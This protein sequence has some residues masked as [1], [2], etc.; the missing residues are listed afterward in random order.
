[1]GEL[2]C[3]FG[4]TRGDT[5]R[6]IAM[7]DG[8]S[9]VAM[10]LTSLLDSQTSPLHDEK[11][12]LKR[13][14]TVPALSNPTRR[15]LT[16]R[17]DWR[18]VAKKNDS[19]RLAEINGVNMFSMKYDVS[20]NQDTLYGRND[21]PLL[22]FDYSETGELRRVLDGT[23]DEDSYRL[24]EMNVTFDSLGRRSEV[25]WGKS[26]IQ[27]AYDSQHRV[28]ERNHEGAFV[29]QQFRYSKS[30]RHPSFVEQGGLKHSIKYDNHDRLKEITSPS[31]EVHTFSCISMGGGEWILKRRYAFANKPILFA[32]D[33]SGK[34]KEAVTPDGLHH[35]VVQRDI[36]SR[37][38][39]VFNDEEKTRV[40]RWRPTGEALCTS[41]PNYM[42]NSTLQGPLLAWFSV[43]KNSS[44]GV[45]TSSF[46]YEYDDLHRPTSIQVVADGIAVEPMKFSYDEKNGRL[47]ALNGFTLLHEPSITRVSGNSILHEIFL[48]DHR[49]V[50]AR[51]WM[52]GDVRVSL[53]IQRDSVGRPFASEWRMPN[54]DVILQSVTFDSFGRLAT[55]ENDSKKVT[56]TYNTD[57]RV[58]KVD[59]LTVEWHSSG[60][61]KKVADTEYS[62]DENG[63][64]TGRGN[65]TFSYDA[66]GRLVTAQTVMTLFQFQYDHLDRVISISKNDEHTSLLYG[67]PS[68]PR[69]LTHFV[70]SAGVATL[71]YDDDDAPFAV[72]IDGSYYALGIDEHN[73]LRFVLSEAG[74]LKV[75]KR[76]VLGK[77]VQ[78]SK[79]DLWLPI[80]FLGGIEIA[81]LCV[82]ILDGRPLDNSLGRYLSYSVLSLSRLSF[83]SLTSSL[84]LFA[85]EDHRNPYRVPSIP[86]DMPSW[87]G[88][89]ALS[90]SLLPSETFGLP[91]DRTTTYRLLSSFPSRLH[92]F[93]HLNTIL[94]SPL[95]DP[96]SKEM[97][98]S[99]DVKWSVE[100]IGFSNLVIVSLN[101]NKT[102]VNALPTLKEDEVKT[103]KSI[104]DGAQMINFRT[105]VSVQAIHLLSPSSMTSLSSSANSHFTLVASRESAELRSG[106]T[107]IVVHFSN[108]LNAVRKNLVDELRS[109][110][111]AMV[112]RAERKRVQNGVISVFPWSDR[113][114]REL[115][116]K[117][118]VTGV[119]IEMKKS[120]QIAVFPS[121][122]SWRS[123]F[124]V[125]CEMGLSFR[126]ILAFFLLEAFSIVSVFT[127]SSTNSRIT[128]RALL[129]EKLRR[130]LVDLVN[131]GSFQSTDVRDRFI[132][133]VVES[134]EKIF[135]LGAR[136]RAETAS[137]FCRS[138]ADRQFQPIQLLFRDAIVFGA[139]RSIPSPLLNLTML[140]PRR[141]FRVSNSRTHEDLVH[142]VSL[143][144]SHKEIS[145]FRQFVRVNLQG[146]WNPTKKLRGVALL[147]DNK[148][149]NGHLLPRT[150][151]ARLEV[152]PE[153]EKPR[154][155][156]RNVCQSN[157]GM[158]QPCCL[159]PFSRR[160][161]NET[162]KFH[163]C[164]GEVLPEEAI[165]VLD[166]SLSRLLT[167]GGMTRLITAPEKTC[168]ETS[169]RTA[170]ID[171]DDAVLGKKSVLLNRL[172]ATECDQRPATVKGS[173]HVVPAQ[174]E[175]TTTACAATRYQRP[176]EKFAMSFSVP[177]D[178]S[179]GL[180]FLQGRRT[181][182]DSSDTFDVL[183]P[184]TGTVVAKCPKASAEHV[185]EAVRA[186]HEAQGEW[187]SMTALDRG[188]VLRKAAEIIRENLE[189]IAKWE[190]KTNGKP[191]YEARVD[192][193][194]SADSFDFYGGIATAALQG[195]T[196]ICSENRFAYTR[197]EPLGVV[198]CIGAWNYPFQTCVWKVAPALAAGNCVVYKPSPFA[199]A[200]PVLLGEI[201]TAAGVPK[202]VF[203]VVQGEQA[204]GVAICE[205]D[206]VRKLS[207]TG[208]V[209]GG[210]SVQRQGAKDNV[211]PVTLELGGKSEIIIFD[212]SDIESAV[213]A[214]MLANFL[215]QGQVCTNATRV[216]VQRGILEKFT[217]AVVKEAN[218]KLKIGDPLK[219][220]TRVGANINEL[221]LNKILGY[222]ESA[223]QEGGK[224]LRGGTRVHPE[225]VENGFYFDPAIITGLND[226]SK[227]V[228]EE[229]FGAV[230]IILPFE[231]E[232]EVVK[233][234]NNTM[235]GLAA[236]VF[237]K[238]LGRCHRIATKLQAGTVFLNSYNDT[239]VNVP[240][241]G[242]KN[243]GHGREN[244]VDT[245]KSYTQIKAIYVNAQDTTEHCF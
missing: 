226:D 180:F 161:L 224:V 165:S 80:G 118:S 120:H 193:T 35:L 212:D 138:L 201:L 16:T 53:S 4:E 66:L 103:L 92:S 203:N 196:K 2:Y 211:K 150:L 93:S 184:R 199:P 89:T 178:L 197:R 90:A 209:A 148:W 32:L 68:S 100:D 7:D 72:S 71:F 113:Q 97:R 183:E 124:C 31:G 86:T 36:S 62:V 13:R 134:H 169:F 28:V 122:H 21:E 170:R 132:D 157:L 143:T 34:L 54:S 230:M 69:Q 88:L 222:V 64:V 144:L 142:L 42:T 171:V 48:D 200:S 67:N 119:D 168:R 136:Q 39:Q 181:T 108:D 192:I 33:R 65:A 55:V 141:W 9:L 220:D 82:T 59:D 237:S 73:S 207:F 74:V 25:Q 117:G 125:V 217:E 63:W 58:V 182:V 51:K 109:R 49:R 176:L 98:P 18:F 24:A 38:L 11:A 152:H 56:F 154:F 114:K 61:P 70:T 215:N 78:D 177:K 96:Q 175:S 166:P 163:R 214:A 195:V 218:E 223:K 186:A 210:L 22:I 43:W 129:K 245:L 12:L 241:G 107:R 110:E 26:K 19:R 44:Q 137:K 79:P 87:F 106:K 127:K 3:G 167:P 188:K 47:S 101:I 162:F 216:F 85:L 81:E 187:G 155:L 130:V 205:H 112:W 158:K 1:M 60:V 83:S 95:V 20:Q 126:L 14:T 140:I 131:D 37:V 219:E 23:S 76:D 46:S 233:R 227:A 151:R 133:G 149:N 225:G 57:G 160:N 41:S 29:A 213:A 135:L 185:D 6:L 242:F 52:L 75:V 159:W 50:V 153:F 84:D 228:R 232:E 239:E 116:S 123:S 191:I 194:S 99:D 17:W 173:R 240:F 5:T 146:L 190:V 10:G 40:T 27:A 179:H 243:S 202:S 145:P 189:E 174:Q 172:D 128:E 102:F 206:L 198:G 238:N 77:V 139:D 8:Y 156:T 229:I 204:T 91:P 104:I 111:S 236:G 30:Q 105:W 231:T 121:S 115:L 164:L 235:Y 234:A 147:L 94:T 221:H 15:S 45:K 208:S 244:C